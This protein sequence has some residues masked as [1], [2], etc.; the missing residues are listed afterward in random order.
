MRDVIVMVRKGPQGKGRYPCRL[1][2]IVLGREPGSDGLILS[3]D[4][5]V[6]RRHGELLTRGQSVLYR[7][8]SPNGSLVDGTVVQDTAP[9][10]P[11][12]KIQ[13]GNRYVLEVHF[14]ATPRE[15]TRGTGDSGEVWWRRGPLA[16]PLVRVLLVAY[17]VGLGGVATFFGLRS[18]PDVLAEFGATRQVYANDYLVRTLPPEHREE[19]LERAERL[20]LK[21]QALERMEDWD[22]ARLACRA[23]MAL[24]GDPDSPVFRFAA[25]RHADLAGRR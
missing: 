21:L 19:R 5:S 14:E 15:E 23:L 7:N 6:S 4:P 2:R 18:E 20:L 12:S 1:G 11:G 10:G 25:D 8:L 24:D 13:L 17:L 9:L 22:E 3:G 16:Q